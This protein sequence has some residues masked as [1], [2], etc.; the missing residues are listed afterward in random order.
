MHDPAPRAHALSQAGAD[1]AVVALRVAV[2]DLTGDHPCDDLHVSMMM[3]AEAASP[4]D[5]VVVAHQQQPMMRVGRIVVIGE[6]ERMPRVEPI[7]LRVE[8]GLGRSDIDAH[9]VTLWRDRARGT[10]SSCAASSGVATGR[11]TA[12]HNSTARATTSALV[13]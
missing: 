13:G 4:V 5:D 8:A 9:A 1:D 6:A 10:S 3:H 11:P 2:L 7:D 12:A